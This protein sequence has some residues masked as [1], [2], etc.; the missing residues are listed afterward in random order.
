MNKE[1]MGEEQEV[2][3][4]GVVVTTKHRGVFFGYVSTGHDL[5]TQSLWVSNARMCVSWSADNHGVVGLAS[6]GPTQRA[7]ITPAAPMILLHDVTSVM[8]CTAE[9]VAAW[10]S[11]PWS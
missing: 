9:A 11:E 6:R 7:R 8:K 3:S 2:K 10:E 1:D 5:E 4:V